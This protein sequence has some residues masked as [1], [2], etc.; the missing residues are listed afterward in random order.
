MQWNPME[1]IPR[2]WN[3]IRIE[4]SKISGIGMKSELKIL[5]FSI[6]N[7]NSIFNEIMAQNNEFWSVFIFWVWICFGST[8]SA[9][10]FAA[11]FGTN[12]NLLQKI[13]CWLSIFISTF[14]IMSILLSAASL[15]Y[16]LIPLYKLLNSRI[17]SNSVR[18]SIRIKIKAKF[19]FIN[20]FIHKICFISK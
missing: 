11:L 14:V 19:L 12:M 9:I 15:N 4:N 10:L 7:L 3:G 1:S 5:Y 18:I 8:I 16:K 6:T 13:I 17:A 20:S 2:N